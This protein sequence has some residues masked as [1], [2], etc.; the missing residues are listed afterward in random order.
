LLRPSLLEV[1]C[2]MNTKFR[3]WDSRNKE[4]IYSDKEDCFYITT[5]GVLFMYAIPK[6][7]SGLTVEYYKDYTS[8]QFTGLQDKN[9]VDIYEGDIVQSVDYYPSEIVYSEY[10]AC[11]LAGDLV[12]AD[13][14]CYR[15]S[16]RWEVIGN[17]HEN[18]EL[19]E[20]NE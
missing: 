15:T 8:K 13:G 12:I 1:V 9:G 6:S 2:V 19:L 10:K 17:I 14:G 18:P 11:F 16:N 3:C 7:E 20:G 4:M 5:K